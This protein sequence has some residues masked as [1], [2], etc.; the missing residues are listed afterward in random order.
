MV[1]LVHYDISCQFELDIQHSRRGSLI[2]FL[3]VA[4]QEARQIILH[5]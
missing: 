1:F 4:E 5:Y 3:L 2:K